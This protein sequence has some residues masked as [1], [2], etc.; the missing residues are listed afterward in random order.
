MTFRN[1]KLQLISL[2]FSLCLL[3]CSDVKHD[4]PVRLMAPMQESSVS[5]K[6]ETF[7]LVC[8]TIR[9]KFFDPEFRGVNWNELCKS[10]RLNVEKKLTSSAF[11]K[12]LN[13]MLEQLKTSHTQYYSPKDLNY[14]LVFDVFN[15]NPNLN[16]HRERLFGEGDVTFKGIGIF[17]KKINET[18]FIEAIVEGTPAHDAGFLIGDEIISVN[19][20]AFHPIQSFLLSG[21]IP[22]TIA[23]KRS[24]DQPIQEIEVMAVPLNPRQMFLEAMRKSARIIEH[25]NKK[26]GYIH[27]WSSAGEEYNNVLSEM[28]QAGPLS[29][30]DAIIMD[31]RGKLGGG[32]FDYLETLNPR[33]PSLTI[34]G[35]GFT[36]NEDRNFK[37]KTVWLIN[38]GVRSTGE[39]LAYVIRKDQYGPMVGSR[40]AGAVVGGSPYIMP[41]DGLLYVAVVDLSIDGK[42]LEG[43]GVEPDIN[44][45]FPISYA[46]G[47]DPQLNRAIEEAVKLAQ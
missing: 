36:S 32:G 10:Q 11:S 25:D 33:I 45:K 38:D 15:R 13:G 1:R 31:M 41:D 34:S 40:T 21:D 39:M 2:F 19:G 35:R 6:L 16:E 47:N 12:L 20:K 30:A 8:D 46:E 27:I 43:V 26:I 18:T 7:D 4:S 44:V 29:E 37:N 3:G 9:E 42:R 24:K 5:Q 23:I 17:T 14:Y 28:M 22:L